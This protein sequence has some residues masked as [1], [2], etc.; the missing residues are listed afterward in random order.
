[1]A[2][3]GLSQRHTKPAVVSASPKEVKALRNHLKM[4]RQAFANWI[5]VNLMTIEAWETG[6]KKLDPIESKVIR[7]AMGHPDW[8]KEFARPELLSAA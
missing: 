3:T 8:V 4:T 1:M 6:A 7:Y 2:K 5:G